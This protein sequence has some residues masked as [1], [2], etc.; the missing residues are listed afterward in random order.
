LLSRLAVLRLH[1]G[2]K[3]GYSRICEQLLAEQIELREATARRGFLWLNIEPYTLAP[4]AV[5]DPGTVLRLVEKQVALEG[6]P[7]GVGLG[8]R[9]FELGQARYRAGKYDDALLALARPVGLASNTAGHWF[10]L[11]MAQHRSSNP[12][13]QAKAQASLARGIERL[14][15]EE[16]SR[17]E[18]PEFWRASDEP[19]GWQQRLMNRMLRREAEEELK[20]PGGKT[21]QEQ[22]NG[23]RGWNVLKETCR[24][25]RLSQPHGRSSLIAVLAQWMDAF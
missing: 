4:G 13:Q 8:R 22:T 5:K 12:D 2:D 19:S 25:S 1:L 7:P 10:F 20:K 17:E 14:E 9:G 15:A 18:T 6:G 16:R 11:A 23:L 24:P 21:H 3:A